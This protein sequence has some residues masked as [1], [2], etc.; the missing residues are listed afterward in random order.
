MESER[1]IIQDLINYIHNILEFVNV[2]DFEDEENV[3]IVQDGY[4]T[5]VQPA[6]DYL[7]K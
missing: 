5:L 3:S 7:N 4:E 2:E 6:I 1:K